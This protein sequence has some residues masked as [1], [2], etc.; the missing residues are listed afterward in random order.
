MPIQGIHTVVLKGP[1]PALKGPGTYACVPGESGEGDLVLDV[2]SE[3]LP[4]FLAIRWH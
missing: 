3:D 4:A 1:F 2:K